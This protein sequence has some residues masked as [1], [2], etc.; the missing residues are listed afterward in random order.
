MNAAEIARNAT[1]PE[2]SAWVSANAGAGKTKVLT[3]RV[4]RAGRMEGNFIGNRELKV[5]EPG[6]PWRGETPGR[7]DLRPAA[8]RRGDIHGEDW[9]A[10]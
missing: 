6:I 10:G 7:L 9:L 5:S 8:T 1:D 2:S 3:D 4:V